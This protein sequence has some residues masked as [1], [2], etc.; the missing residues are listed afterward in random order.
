MTELG[1]Q[2]TYILIEIHL[3]PVN[4]PDNGITELGLA[5]EA[6]QGISVIPFGPSMYVK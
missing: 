2:T 6:K 1:T 4:K 5:I 3:L